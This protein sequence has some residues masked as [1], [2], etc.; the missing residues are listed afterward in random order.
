MSSGYMYPWETWMDGQ[1][2]TLRR[3]R[4][5]SV[6]VKNFASAAYMWA[7]R[8]GM[9][10]RTEIPSPGTVIIRRTGGGSIIPVRFAMTDAGWMISVARSRAHLAADLTVEETLELAI[11]VRKLEDGLRGLKKDLQGKGKPHMGYREDREIPRF[12]ADDLDP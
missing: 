4:D 12:G 1:E 10:V 3:G 11:A 2:H 8:N 7:R 6:G 5:F 9:T